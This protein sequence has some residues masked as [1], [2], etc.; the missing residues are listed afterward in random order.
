MLRLARV[1]KARA[2]CVL[3]TAAAAS[4]MCA[5]AALADNVRGTWSAPADWPLIA[6][7]AVLTPDGRVLTYGTTAEGQQTGKLP[8]SQA[9]M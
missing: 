7:H 8:M 9:V 1:S 6:I 2:A 5:T 3:A 4:F